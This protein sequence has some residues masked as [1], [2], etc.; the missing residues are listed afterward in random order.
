MLITGIPFTAVAFDTR[1][2]K[3]YKDICILLTYARFI[4]YYHYYARVG[5]RITT[6]NQRIYDATCPYVT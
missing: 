4:Y 3:I 6:G 5:N 2:L 1:V